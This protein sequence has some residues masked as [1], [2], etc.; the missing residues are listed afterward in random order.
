MRLNPRLHELNLAALTAALVATTAGSAAAAT[1]V[2]ND[3]TITGEG[4]FSLTVPT[5]EAVDA[6]L[7]EAGIRAIFAGDFAAAKLAE[8]DAAAIRIPELTLTAE[9]AD[10]EGTLRRSVIVYRD[11]EI[12][13]I[14]DGVA[15]STAI[16]GAE[17]EGVEGTSFTFGRM[18]T[19]LFDIGGV[20]G[21]YGF[22]AGSGDGEMKTIYE[23]FVFEGVSFTAP[24]LQC[25]FGAATLAEFRARPLE[26][27]FADMMTLSQQ[28]ETAQAAGEPPP[29][30]VVTGFV[31]YY[32][33]FLTAFA[34]SPLEATGLSCSGSDHTGGQVRIELG[35]V[36]MG[37]FE[38]GIYPPLSL[39]DFRLETTDKGWM[40]LENFTWK[41]A[42]LTGPLA[43]VEA[44]G[45]ELGEAWFEANWR[46]I[47]P[48]FE[49]LSLRGF[50][51]DIADPESPG[52]RLVAGIGAF[53]LTLGD[54][55]NGIPSSFS[56]TTDNVEFELPATGDT[57]GL[58]ALGIERLDL[59]S[60][61]AARWDEASQTITVENVMVEA[62]GLG[63]I[64]VSGTLVNATADLFSEDPDVAT[65]ALTGLAVTDLQI[66]LENRGFLPIL[67]AFAAR[68]EGQPPQALH[69]A[70]VGMGTALPIGLL[71][72]TPE[73]VE[74]GTSIAAFLG[75]TPQLTL[76]VVAKD[77]AGIGLAD[78]MAAESDPTALAGK[79][80]V[81]ATTAGEQQALEFPE[82]PPQPSE[83][84]AGAA[85]DTEAE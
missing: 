77:P 63:R 47:I 21:F 83:P 38:P 44:A 11:I 13:D 85:E 51:M 58:V 68:D 19:G 6:S 73:S 57:A 84:E 22:A 64:G 33:D 26:V 40:E 42:D 7:D 14:V 36:T 54:Y 5:I 18:S 41:R 71:G 70:L 52:K 80:T 39:N 67:V 56:T 45:D 46:R 53:D 16:G 25:E 50:G 15:A 4:G 27:S 65:L 62:A 43:A 8:L 60:D 61:I 75:G 35:P 29:P 76:N 10:P 28:L 69:A 74:V 32:V 37:G 9:V 17:V 23:D 34:S 30:G 81:T 3:I 59:S 12:V 1:L 82:L 48:A 31:R 49:G 72:A 2:V 20:A 66:Q 55:V 78:L 79:I 24:E